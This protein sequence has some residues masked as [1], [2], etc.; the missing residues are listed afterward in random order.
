VG[1]SAAHDSVP[2]VR[3]PSL[4]LFVEWC[5]LEVTTAS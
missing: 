2:G 1:G 3:H 4:A 5:C